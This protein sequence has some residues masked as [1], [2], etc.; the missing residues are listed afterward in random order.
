MRAALLAVFAA[1]L[2]GCG[3]N[4]GSVSGT[5]TLD[6][7]PFAGSDHL[8][9]TVQ[10]I[11]ETG[12]G[13]VASGYLDESGNYELSSG[14]RVGV[15]PG[16]YVVTVSAIEIIPP[17]IPGGAAGGKA[18]SPPRYANPQTSGFTAEVVRGHN[19]FDF[20][21]LSQPTH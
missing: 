8:R 12:H 7:K 11:P 2:I 13:M 18:A 4:L 3:S 19:T 10:F 20:A 6:G 16:K 5:V 15:L 9:G 17:K 14:S 1:T 21:L